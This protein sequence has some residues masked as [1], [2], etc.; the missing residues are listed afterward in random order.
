[1]RKFIYFSKAKV[2]LID[3]YPH[4]SF[5]KRLFLYIVLN[6]NFLCES[7]DNGL[8]DGLINFKNRILLVLKSKIKLYEQL[9]ISFYVFKFTRASVTESFV[10]TNDDVVGKPNVISAQS[11]A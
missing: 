5:F 2:P 6:V 4:F 8:I 9:G 3:L 7:I 1:M 11:V 10:F